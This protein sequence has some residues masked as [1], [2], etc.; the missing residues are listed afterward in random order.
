MAVPKG[1]DA[2]DTSQGSDTPPTAEGQSPATAGSAFSA[3]GGDD[4]QDL[5]PVLIFP[6]FMADGWF[7]RSELPR[8]LAEA[9]LPP[10]RMHLLAPFGTDPAAID[11]AEAVLR[12][13]VAERGWRLAET[14]LLLAAHGS[15]RSPAPAAVAR[16]VARVLVDRLR[17]ASLATGFIDQAP[18]VAAIARECPAPALCLPFFALAGGHVEEDLPAALASAGFPGTL[19][20]PL[21]QAEEA[22]ALVARALRAAVAAAGDRTGAGPEGAADR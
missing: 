14:H 18:Q 13:A 9:G 11:L 20:P 19:L 3:T 17:P 6:M 10:A 21:G 15:F 22:P 12:A 5:P 8:R 7:T 4:P 1:A 2:P 16:R